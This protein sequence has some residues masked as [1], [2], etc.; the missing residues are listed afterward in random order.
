MRSF[1]VTDSLIT[2]WTYDVEKGVYGY[3]LDSDEGES[4]LAKEIELPIELLQ[5]EQTRHKE[6]QTTDREEPDE[7]YDG[8]ANGV[9]HNEGECV[10]CVDIYKCLWFWSDDISVVL[11]H[12]SRAWRI[13]EKWSFYRGSCEYPQ[14]NQHVQIHWYHI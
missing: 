2:P 10:H 11:H 4:R 1:L 12:I 5:E 9:Q 13:Q 3:E 8:D 6:E 14:K 7:Q